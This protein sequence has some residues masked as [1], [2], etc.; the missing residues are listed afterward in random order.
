LKGLRVTWKTLAQTADKKFSVA[1]GEKSVDVEMGKTYDFDTDSAD[2]KVLGYTVQVFSEDKV[3]ASAVEPADIK[4]Q[5]EKAG[6][7]SSK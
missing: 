7:S 4:A 6:G 3:L 1:Q 5:I 2:G